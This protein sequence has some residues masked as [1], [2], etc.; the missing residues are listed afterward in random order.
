MT[1]SAQSIDPVKLDS[2]IW[3]IVPSNNKYAVSNLGRIKSINRTLVVTDPKYNRVYTTTRKE[4]I[5][6]PSANQRGYLRVD[7]RS[8][9]RKSGYTAVVHRLVAEAFIPNPENKPQ[10]N[11]KDGNKQNNCVDNL[12]WCT[13]LENNR[14][15][16]KL[17]LYPKPFTRIW[18]H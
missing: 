14:H 5:I 13:N 7:M 4:K 10:V 18:T 1:S 9:D 2:E 8:T 17:G 12:E 3:I 16:R 6:T 15:A 11:H